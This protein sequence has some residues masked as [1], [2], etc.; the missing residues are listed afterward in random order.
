[1]VQISMFPDV[2]VMLMY[3]LPPLNPSWR[4]G[5]K[6][7]SGDPTKITV[8][9]R[10][11]AGSNSNIGIDRPVVDIDV[12]GPKAQTGNVSVAARTIQSQMLSLMSVVVMGGGGTRVGVIQ[13][14]TTVAGPR[15]LPEVNQN[16]V[17][18]SASYELKIHS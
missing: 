10:R 9:L 13:H 18:F 12:F 6:L 15:E 4:F 14:V 16:F 17:R 8:R 5:T 2:E 3:V 11:T 1:M 7:P